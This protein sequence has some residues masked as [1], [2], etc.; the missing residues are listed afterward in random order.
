VTL[1]EFQTAIATTIAAQV[2]TANVD[3]HGGEYTWEAI[4]RYAANDPC[5][6]IS[7]AGA[8][9]EQGTFPSQMTAHV[10]VAVSVITQTRAGA[11][12]G[13]HTRGLRYTTELLRVV[14]Q[15]GQYWGLP[16][17]NKCLQVPKGLRAENLYS[18]KLDSNDIAMWGVTWKQMV[19]L[20]DDT[21]IP[22][23]F[24]LFHA[25]YDLAPT[26]GEYEASDDVDVS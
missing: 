15:F 13:R 19:D 5:I 10:S 12:G 21:A 11:A 20:I 25:D 3:T 24:E 16:A 17:S 6:M 22:I 18:S 2:P 14:N 23:D 1:D 26:D 4:S 8:K 9:V 7:L